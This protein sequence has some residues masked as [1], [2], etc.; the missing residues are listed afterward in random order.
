MY[1]S[2]SLECRAATSVKLFDHCFY[3][4]R[5]AGISAASAGRSCWLSARNWARRSGEMLGLVCIMLGNVFDVTS[6][7]IA[8]QEH[9]VHQRLRRCESMS[10]SGFGLSIGWRANVRL[11]RTL[12]QNNLASRECC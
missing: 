8:P 2:I 5:T 9:P 4:S 7:G 11:G 6:G 10:H 12:G 3:S 1:S